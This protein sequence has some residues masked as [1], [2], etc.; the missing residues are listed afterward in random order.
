MRFWPSSHWPDGRSRAHA[1]RTYLASPDRGEVLFSDVEGSA[2]RLA[3]AADRHG[4]SDIARKARA[5][6]EAESTADAV[7]IDEG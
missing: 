6:V 7:L 5:T 3:A 1:A 2:Q 4:W